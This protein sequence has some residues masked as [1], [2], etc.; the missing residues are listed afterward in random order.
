MT[1]YESTL[2]T[3]PFLVATSIL[4]ELT[5]N[6]VILGSSGLLAG[7]SFRKC[8]GIV[9]IAISSHEIR[10]KNTGLLPSADSKSKKIAN[11]AG[12]VHPTQSRILVGVENTS[13]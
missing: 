12:P 2:D 9:G 10:L 13:K 7:R 11:G 8:T 4:L 1:D 3:V 6:T 5:R